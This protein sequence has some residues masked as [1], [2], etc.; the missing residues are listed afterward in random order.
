M[1]NDPNPKAPV[2]TKPLVILFLAILAVRLTLA[3]ERPALG[4]TVSLGLSAQPAPAV[5]LQPVSTST[6]GIAFTLS[7]PASGDFALTAPLSTWFGLGELNWTLTLPAGAPTNVQVL[8]FMK[9]WDYLWYQ[10]LLPGCA[11][12]GVTNHYRVDLSASAPKWEPHGHHGVWNARTLMEPR[13]FGI[14]VFLDGPG[15]VT[16]LLA[17]VAATRPPADTTP[18][19]IRDVRPSARQ[20]A[21]YDKFEITFEIPDRYANPFDPEEVA[22][23]ATL[24]TPDGQTVSID[25]FH[26]LNYYRTTAP[27]G[28]E[29]LPQG[30]PHWK[31]R[32]A[33]TR[34]GV[35]HYTLHVRD[36][37]G[38]AAWGPGS[39]VA[40]PPA[41]PG[42]VR[43]AR[44]DR[45]FFEFDS[46]APYFPIGHNIRSPSDERLNTQ[47]PWAKRWPEG[48]SAYTRHFAAMQ[49][50]GENMAEIWMAAWSLGLEWSPQWRGY[51][52]VGQYN[53]IN[54]WELDRVIDAADRHGIYL[55]VV[56]HNHGKFSG[57]LDSEWEA[58]PFNRKLGGFL[59]KPDE[60]FSDPRALKAF[61]QLMRYIVA[62]W[63][64]ST[65]V[66]AWELWSE[67][68]LAGANN[69]FY[70]TPECVNWHRFATDAIRDLDPND[71]LITTHYSSD[72]TF[73]NMDITALPGITHASVDAYHG[74][75][76][77]LQI[78]DLLAATAQFNNPTDKPVMVTEFGGNWN[79]QGLVHLENSL[80]AGLWAS[81]CIPLAGTPLFWW[82]GLIEEENYYPEFLAI[83]RFMK[84]EDRRDRSLLPHLPA[85]SLA[86]APEAR[87]KARSL[88]SET[89]ALGWIYD[90]TAFSTTDSD[91]HPT[92]SNLVTRLDGMSN[93]LY[94]VEFWGT[95]AG[96]PTTQQDIEVK[97]GFLSVTVPPF[98]RDIAFKVR[99]R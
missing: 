29:T 94:R 77:T 48:T 1:R 49:E 45:R 46:G 28:E 61:R 21:C 6:N 56:L 91:A 2:K 12:P 80:H 83:A 59:E 40:T 87:F 32:Y 68:N 58:N 7:G 78:V 19:S 36:T 11:S 97:E 43:V 13:E 74:D 92:V 90:T 47:F 24:E 16:G 41:Q 67:L 71:H 31:I 93:G 52:G 26:S 82:W 84:G 72:Y 65:R 95:S 14:R 66:F 99:K 42:Y 3:E 76:R 96:V 27:T 54:A 5:A 75:S 8:V 22:V 4:E 89:R 33:P 25:G 51:H 57:H 98:A 81:T 23:T 69:K 88:K 9:D 86:G 39:F 10:Q 50:H 70:R 64:Y 15:A 20:V 17:N 79:A 55:N 44:A 73:Q 30:P 37:R 63:G 34:A 35:H 85:L 53:L 60:Y 18:P 62:R 38:T